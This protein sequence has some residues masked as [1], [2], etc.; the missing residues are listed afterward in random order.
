M[1]RRNYSKGAARSQESS[2]SQGAEYDRMTEAR[3][4]RTIGRAPPRPGDP[5]TRLD[6]A[7]ARDL[8]AFERKWG[9]R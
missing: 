6:E 5:I 7:A 8:A 4:I 1:A 2:R 3:L 9:K